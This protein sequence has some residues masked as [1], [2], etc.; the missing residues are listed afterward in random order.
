MKHN[1]K[2]W[3]ILCIGIMM[4][5][6]VILGITTAVIDP[7]FHYH[8]PLDALTYPLNNQRYQNDGI[9][10]NFEYDA[11]ITGTSMTENFKT[12]EFDAL[13]GT[14]SIKVSYS[15]GTLPEL[16]A[17]LEQALEH[18]P[19]LKTVLLCIDEW[20]L[21]SGRELIQADG[22]YP[23]Y[24]YDDNPFNDVEYLLNREIFWLNTL[25]VLDHTKKGLPTTSFDEYSSWV[26]PYDAEIVLANYNRLEQAEPLPLTE[27]M[28]AQL[29]DTLNH[30]LV[31]M[32]R[33]YPETRFIIY[34][35]PYSI[36]NW[37]QATREGL[38]PRNIGMYSLA[39]EILLEEENIQLFSF[40]SDFETIT[41][42]DNYRDVVHHSDQVNSMLL[43]HF[44]SGQYR[45]T[46]ENYRRHWQEVLDF[47]KS[48]DYDALLAGK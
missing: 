18:N 15:G 24:L 46:K 34:F 2:L 31:K 25:N 21:Y 14:N 20:L 36:L 39:S 4:A 45:L 37:D 12:S 42:L 38:F 7:F 1:S 9:V 5:V 30:T 40:H 43:Q 11:L 28:T 19:A 16:T 10:R 35:P 13:F 33:D 32:A 27:Q 3:S 48:Y 17:N 29:E 26:Y 6:F 8:K 23:N 44:H 41:N 47:Y 22:D